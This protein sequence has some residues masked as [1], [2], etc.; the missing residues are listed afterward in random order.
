MIGL[1]YIGLLATDLI[2]LND[3]HVYEV[4]V[5]TKVVVNIMMNFVF[6]SPYVFY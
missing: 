5:N 3:I 4:D 2:A 1:G 6:V